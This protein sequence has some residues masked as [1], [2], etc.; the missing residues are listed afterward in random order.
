VGAGQDIDRIH[1]QQTQ[2]VDDLVQMRSVFAAW[3][4]GAVQALC[5]KRDAGCF[6]PAECVRSHSAFIAGAAEG[7]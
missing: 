7:R 2:P 4:A 3:T 5:G 6:A 1:L